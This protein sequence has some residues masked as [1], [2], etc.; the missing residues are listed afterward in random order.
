M[1]TERRRAFLVVNKDNFAIQK[2]FERWR[3]QLLPLNKQLQR[4]YGRGYCQDK[5]RSGRAQ[6]IDSGAQIDDFA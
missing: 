4:E 3:T 6:I 5:P 1:R 2:R